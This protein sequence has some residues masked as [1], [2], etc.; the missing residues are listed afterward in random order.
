MLSLTC[1]PPACCPA[2]SPPASP[3]AL[4]PA[5]PPCR[6]DLLERREWFDGSKGREAQRGGSG[7]GSEG[8]DWSGW[9]EA[10]AA[11]TADDSGSRGPLARGLRDW[12]RPG[13]RAADDAGPP[14]EGQLTFLEKLGYSG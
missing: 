13:G 5:F 1:R 7:S 8:D 3:A 12:E 9:W 4:T 6:E 2:H 10:G 14:G 11:S